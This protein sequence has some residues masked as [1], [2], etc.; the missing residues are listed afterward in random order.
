M[1][2]YNIKEGWKKFKPV[3]KKDSATP[4]MTGSRTVAA[5]LGP[6][7]K[8]IPV[9]P[10]A[11]AA[12]NIREWL[13]REKFVEV[14]SKVL[15]ETIYLG[16]K[17]AKVDGVLYLPDELDILAEG[18]PEEETLRTIHEFKRVFGGTLVRE[19]YEGEMLSV[20]CKRAV[21]GGVHPKTCRWH[22]D[23]NDPECKGCERNRNGTKDKR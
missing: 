11:P 10:A 18:K 17:N 20:S 7:T 22:R 1:A 16:H 23:Q 8:K 6:E 14:E 21:S 15:G 12:G 9:E 4:E 3:P 19:G 2:R 5:D 13:E